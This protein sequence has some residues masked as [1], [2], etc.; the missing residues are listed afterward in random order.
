MKRRKMGRKET[1]K[2]H[3]KKKRSEEKGKSGQEILF[4][5]H[6]N[7]LLTPKYN[8]LRTH[9]SLQIANSSILMSRLKC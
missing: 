9:N 7:V 2:M 5:L 4:H 1:K 8:S 3:R 6:I